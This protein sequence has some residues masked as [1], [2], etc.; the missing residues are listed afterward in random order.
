[1]NHKD[2]DVGYG[3]VLRFRR[4]VVDT[5]RTTRSLIVICPTIIG[6]RRALAA[7]CRDVQVSQV[8]LERPEVA[9]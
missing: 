3:A 8:M 7:P 5:T 6:Q 1:M 4:F 9:S 2:R